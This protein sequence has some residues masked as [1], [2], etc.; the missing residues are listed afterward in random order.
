LITHVK[1]QNTTSLEQIFFLSIRYNSIKCQKGISLHWDLCKPL[2]HCSD[3]TNSQDLTL[4]CQ[5]ATI[6]TSE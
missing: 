2:S 6:S 4:F 1:D 5:F 3:N